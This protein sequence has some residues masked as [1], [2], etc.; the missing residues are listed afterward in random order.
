M[1]AVKAVEVLG[2]VR[3]PSEPFLSHKSV[4]H[5]RLESLNPRLIILPQL[6][7]AEHAL[8]CFLSFPSAF[9]NV[10]PLKSFK[11]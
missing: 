11:A 9:L 10:F 8:V 7:P 4:K 2:S 1:R 3:F 6:C 5:L